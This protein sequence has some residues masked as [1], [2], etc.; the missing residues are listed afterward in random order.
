MNSKKLL[1]R[2]F[3]T[4]T[5]LFI[6]FTIFIPLSSAGPMDE[7]INCDPVINVLI[8]EK[9]KNEPI[10]PYS[11]PQNV[12]III[13]CQISGILQDIVSDMY[14]E[15]IYM[16]PTIHKTPEWCTA[17]INPP[18]VKVPVDEE[19][20]S[21]NATVTLTLNKNSPAFEKGEIEINIRTRRLGNKATVISP[22]NKTFIV[23][24]TVG[25]I[26]IIAINHLEGNYK[27]ITPEDTAKFPIELIN[28]GNGKTV[29][30][31]EVLSTPDGW[32]VDIIPLATLN[33]KYLG[34]KY[35][36]TIN[37]AVK[38]S[39]DFGYHEER[40]VIQISVTP[41][42]YVNSSLVGEDHI[43]TFVVHSKGF[44]T[45]GFEGII[46]IFSI[47]ILLF[48]FK[49]NKKSKNNFEEGNR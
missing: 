41:S 45:P 20:Q 4:L 42:S 2:T 7:I 34:E 3:I 27:A 32:I 39:I 38:P 10:M 8:D 33:A 26:P 37:L 13:Q 30:N 16:F 23:P 15:K 19:V 31:T 14:G 17:A 9:T 18:L 43:L 47:I 46:L 28:L 44:T 6:L 29:I 24:F 36:T 35:K 25:Y 49:K 21:T 11:Y 1:T 12:S 40:E 22:T 48:I 5:I